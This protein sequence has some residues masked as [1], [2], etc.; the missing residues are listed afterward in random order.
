MTIIT[1]PRSG[2]REK[3]SM[4][5]AYRPPLVSASNLHSFYWPAEGDTSGYKKK[6]HC[7]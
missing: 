5:C 6:S 4:R 2:Q 1:K 7:I 3:E